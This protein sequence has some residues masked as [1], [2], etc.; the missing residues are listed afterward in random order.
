MSV[1][2]E[3]YVFEI[4]G[5]IDLMRFARRDER[6]ESGEI[7]AMLFIAYKEEVFSFMQSSA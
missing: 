6:K 7:F 1:D 2:P 4:G 3:Q 5:R